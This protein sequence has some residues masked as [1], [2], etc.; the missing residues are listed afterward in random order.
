M[1][2]PIGTFTRPFSATSPW[3]KMTRGAAKLAP[4]NDAQT[5]KMR[6]LAN[7]VDINYQAWTVSPFLGQ[8]SDPL[9]TLSADDAGKT[10]CHI[11]RGSNPSTA[12]G[13]YDSSAVFVDGPTGRVIDFYFGEN[14]KINW[15]ASAFSAHASSMDAN[16][17][18]S[19]DGLNGGSRAS[20]ISALGGLI[21]T[22]E[23]RTGIFH[24]LAIA[25]PGAGLD[26]GKKY[27]WPA[28]SID[29]GSSDYKGNVPMGSFFMLDPAF[30]LSGLSSAGQILATAVRD[31]GCYVLDRSDGCR[32]YGEP[33]ISADPRPSSGDMA[34]IIANVLRVTN[35]SAT[36]AASTTPPVTPP[37]TPPPVIPPITP[38]VTPPAVTSPFPI[39]TDPTKWSNVEQILI[40]ADGKRYKVT[41]LSAIQI[42][43]A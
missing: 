14:P 12:Q 35:N 29:S 28:R 32:F 15:N 25:L 39:K 40:G 43:E 41:T 8:S 13:E 1:T 18:L 20:D 16:N 37:V 11:P 7:T 3:N 26:A 23:L 36:L 19:G 34:K 6:S 17:T 42:E 21:R 4:T 30:N 5:A 2:D 10:T 33:G 31:Y 9:V 38:P 24:A 22:G 27:V